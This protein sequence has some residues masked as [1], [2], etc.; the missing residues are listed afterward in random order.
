M[1][2]SLLDHLNAALDVARTLYKARENYA[3]QQRRQ[4]KRGRQGGGWELP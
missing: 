3:A 1:P 4:S 2:N